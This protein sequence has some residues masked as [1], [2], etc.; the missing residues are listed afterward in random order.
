MD[1]RGYFGEAH[2]WDRGRITTSWLAKQQVLRITYR[3]KDP[4]FIGQRTWTSRIG[5]RPKRRGMRV[6]I[7]SMMR[8]T[9]VSGSSASTK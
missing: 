2:H 9:A 7:N 1:A 4:R 3:N 6:L 8:A 5:S